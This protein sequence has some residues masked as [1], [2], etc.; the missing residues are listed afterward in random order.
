M[1]L[2]LHKR[3]DGSIEIEG[4]PPEYHELSTRMLGRLVA[5]LGAT[6]TVTLRTASGEVVY[7]LERAIVANE[8]L[9]TSPVIAYAFRR[10]GGKRR[11]R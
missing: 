8:E 9:E 10:V 11:K 4:G 3:K 7:E 6:V 5:E 2:V 1:A